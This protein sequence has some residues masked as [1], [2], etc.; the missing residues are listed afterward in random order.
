[1]PQCELNKIQ[2]AETK[3]IRPPCIKRQPLKNTWKRLQSYPPR[4]ALDSEMNVDIT[5]PVIW[6]EWEG[7]GAHNGRK[8]LSWCLCRHI[9]GTYP[10]AAHRIGRVEGSHVY[11][12]N[13]TG[14]EIPLRRKL[15]ADNLLVQ[16][17]SLQ[18][19]LGQEKLSKWERWWHKNCE[20]RQ[21]NRRSC[22]FI[23]FK[24]KHFRCPIRIIPQ[25]KVECATITR[26]I[27]T[28]NSMRNL[29][30]TELHSTACTG[31]FSHSTDPTLAEMPAGAQRIIL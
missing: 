30:H 4:W 22:T 6:Y 3:G 31:E 15:W 28:L 21:N 13:S 14:P 19:P 20:G 11:N 7:K 18:V 10:L 26:K 27:K 17:V 23:V 5:F 24:H 16:S 8:N 1:M 12:L 29:Q 9:V 25:P 2:S